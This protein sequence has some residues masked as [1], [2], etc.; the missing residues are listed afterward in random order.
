MRVLTAVVDEGG[1][2]AASRR[3]GIPL[4][5]V[6]RRV[7]QLEGYLNARLLSRSTRA[8]RLTDVGAAYY[9]S[10]KEILSRIAETEKSATE[11]HGIARGDVVVTAPLLL[12]RLHVLPI[13]KEFTSNFPEIHV[14]LVLSDK[15]LNLVDDHIDIAVRVGRLPDSNMV[16][17]R[18]GSV[19]RVV[20]GSPAYLG[21][22]GRP[23]IP[24]DLATH[25][26]IDFESL[27][28]GPPWAF[29]ANSGTRAERVPVRPRMSVNTADA[30]IEA[31]IDGV[32]L[33]HVLSHQVA[34]AVEKHELELVL[35]EYEPPAIPVS[36]M[37]AAQP[38]LPARTRAFFDF[39]VPHLRTR[40]LRHGH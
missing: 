13:A 17:T 39:A 29:M 16:A 27:P 26:C 21:A 24:S 37:Y 22:R 36:V 9:A 14:R 18:V 15:V 19:Y 10:C 40:L 31:A 8:L 3:L 25:D 12:G 33:A 35:R 30:A 38:N 1:F 2:S 6:S 32:G 34:N 11:G 4:T 7:S 20:C 28:S 23:V 5:T